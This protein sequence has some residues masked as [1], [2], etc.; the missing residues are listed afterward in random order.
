MVMAGGGGGGGGAMMMM[1]GG[2]FGGNRHKYNLTFSINA[3]NVLNHLNE[4]QFNGTLTSPFFGKSNSSGGG[5]GFGGFGFSGARR[6][7][8]SMR[9][10]F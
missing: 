1:G 6:I 10:N 9:F 4:G 8:L 7:D 2:G 3:V 5:G